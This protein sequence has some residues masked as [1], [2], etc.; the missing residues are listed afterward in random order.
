MRLKAWPGTRA[1]TKRL[2]REMS[3]PEVLLWRELRQQELR[4]RK[5]APAGPYTL[6][7]HCAPASLAV[8]VDGEAHGHGDRPARDAVRDAWIAERGVHT[9]RIAASAILRDLDAVLALIVA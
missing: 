1:Q 2:R 7:F 4:W 8:E 3:L 5:G 9:L 6:D